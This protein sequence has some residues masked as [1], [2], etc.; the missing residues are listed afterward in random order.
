MA[1]ER[2]TAERAKQLADEQGYVI[3]D[4]RSAR[5]FN[6]GHPAGAWNVPY[7]EEGRHGMV[8]N[9]HFSE[10]IR[11]LFPE[12]DA[13]VITTCQMG[14]RSVRAANELQQLGYR[15]VLDLRGG[16]GGEKDEAGRTVVAG[17]KDSK[18]PVEVGEPDGR[19]YAALEAR[20]GVKRESE[21]EASHDDGHGH[22]HSHGHGH[23][24]QSAKA[25]AWMRFAHPTAKV[26]CIRH[27]SELPALKRAP[28]GGELGQRL[29]AQVSALAWSE[30]VDHSTLL[31]N[32]YRLNPADPRS[33]QILLEQCEAFFFGEGARRP[34]E[35]VAE[36]GE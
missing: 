6:D 22:A 24:G 27:G 8:P 36:G 30:W 9:E 32:E 17:W 20:A 14:G 28:M 18:L 13:K 1:L 33:Q 12:P 29:K 10:V 25:S 7:L 11:V 34:D 23:G 15:N 16:F 19:G 21:P 4:V 3:L 26:R 35:F 2:V 31:I 5:E